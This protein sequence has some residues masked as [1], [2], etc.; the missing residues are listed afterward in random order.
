MGRVRGD[1]PALILQ[2]LPFRLSLPDPTGSDPALKPL[3]C[4]APVGII[5][6]SPCFQVGGLHLASDQEDREVWVLR[7]AAGDKRSY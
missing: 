7:V 1:R 5:R 4:L 2:P 6:I 3:G